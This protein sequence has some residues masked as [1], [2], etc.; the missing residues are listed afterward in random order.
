MNIDLLMLLMTAGGSFAAGWYFHNRKMETSMTALMHRF[1]DE[2]TRMER[3]FKFYDG[4]FTAT[5]ELF[6]MQKYQA[7]IAESIFEWTDKK[8]KLLLQI[9]ELEPMVHEKMRLVDES[10]QSQKN[11]TDRELKKLTAQS[12]E[13]NKNNP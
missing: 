12:E 8:N 13:L 7:S 6:D 5:Y 3:S 11:S 10:K 2:L 1:H 4:K 9:K